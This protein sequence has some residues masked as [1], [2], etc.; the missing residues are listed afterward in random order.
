MY[1]YDLELYLGSGASVLGAPLEVQWGFA[2]GTEWRIDY[3]LAFVR[4]GGPFYEDTLWSVCTHIYRRYTGY[5]GDG[6]MLG[7]G[8]GLEAGLAIEFRV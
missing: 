5:A 8:D 4:Q 3:R 6:G 7:S 2:A 1:S